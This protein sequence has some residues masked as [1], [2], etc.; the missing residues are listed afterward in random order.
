M[1]R[2]SS[3]SGA[4]ADLGGAIGAS[5]VAGAGGFLYDR[6]LRTGVSGELVGMTADC[7]GDVAVG[8]ADGIGES[9]NLVSQNFLGE[10]QTR[11]IRERKLVQLSLC[12]CFMTAPVF[13]LKLALESDNFKGLDRT[14]LNARVANKLV[15]IAGILFKR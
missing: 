5:G 1:Q 15:K 9:L 13:P 6:V 11:G 7:M 8:E 10:A 2:I 3:A 4:S 14:K 12:G